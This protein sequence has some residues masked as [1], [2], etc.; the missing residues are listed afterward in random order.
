M[1]TAMAKSSPSPGAAAPSPDPPSLSGRLVGSLPGNAAGAASTA[2]LRD[3]HSGTVLAQARIASDG[4]FE[5]AALPATL[6]GQSHRIDLIVAEAEGSAAAASIAVDFPRTGD[7]SILVNPGFGSGAGSLSP[8]PELLNAGRLD[9]LLQGHEASA[10]AFAQ[11]RHAARERNPAAAVDLAEAAEYLES[12]RRPQHSAGLHVP[13][14][15]LPVFDPE[16]VLTR[17]SSGLSGNPAARKAR[18]RL[19]DAEQSTLQIG[20]PTVCNAVS[21]R[22]D[23]RTLERRPLLRERLELAMRIERLEIPPTPEMP[24]EPEPAPAGEE[25]DVTD[26]ERAAEIAALGRAANV[27]ADLGPELTE[28]STTT[29]LKRL[30]A[31]AA[32]LEL[33][34]GPAN[35]A[36][37]REVHTLQVAFDQAATTLVDKDLVV[38]WSRWNGLRKRLLD[39]RSLSVPDPPT[40]LTRDQVR[41]YLSESKRLIAANANEPVP[42][43]VRTSYPRLTSQQWAGLSDEARDLV[44]ARSAAGGTTLRFLGP[45]GDIADTVAEAGSALLDAA[46]DL[47]GFNGSGSD[48][49]GIPQQP[50][51][52]HVRNTR[53]AARVRNT[54]RLAHAAATRHRRNRLS[55]PDFPGRDPTHLLLIDNRDRVLFIHAR[56]PDD[57]EH[58]RWELPGG[59]LD[60]GES[61][62]H[63]AAREVA[64][65]TGIEIDTV[66]PV[67]GSASHA[68][69]TAAAVAATRQTDNQKLGLIERAWLT[70]S[71]LQ[72]GQSRW[73]SRQR[74]TAVQKVRHAD[75]GTTSMPPAGF[76][77]SRM[78]AAAG[79]QAIS[80]QD[81]LPLPLLKPDFWPRQL[82]QERRVCSGP[83]AWTRWCSHNVWNRVRFFSSW[84]GST[85]EYRTPTPTSA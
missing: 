20:V 53:L 74:V 38:A 35:V 5:M 19:T 85:P 83:R 36:A 79:T 22:K 40:G 34:G 50:T 84:R 45:I 3:G 61:L 42:Q 43:Q 6:R 77:E 48:D 17:P 70:V 57:P 63:A 73:G 26:L 7:A 33:A 28:P 13:A 65:E 12:I 81:E 71:D 69:A 2:V 58:H 11:T 55:V 52:T 66:A 14:R 78:A 18:L 68:S 80:A 23:Q 31:L 64:E 27:I 82:P 21:A 32:E 15:E 29:D 30:H 60:D 62:E 4:T 76:V 54:G 75:P 56:D 59:G 24:A 49:R 8:L 44:V 37:A 9:D 51:F 39:E 1:L 25:P 47:A 67:S 10:E 46:A 72:T 41:S 16:S